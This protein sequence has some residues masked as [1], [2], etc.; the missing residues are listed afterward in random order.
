[1]SFVSE[2]RRRNVLRV[3][4][5]YLV[6]G[7]L[8]TEVL[9][10]I[11]P[12]LGAPAW[13]ARM[14]ILIFA[15]G[16]PLA[17]VLPWIYEL[18][19]EGIKR[20]SDIGK[21]DRVR[22]NTRRF[23]YF[24]FA[25]IAILIVVV[26]VLGA[27]TAIDQTES[28]AT[29]A[30]DTSIAVLPFVNLTGD[31]GNN[32]LSDGLTETLLHMLT[33]HQELLVAA[34]TSSFAFKNQDKT[35]LEIADALN[36]AHILEGSVQLAN[37]KIRITAQL[38]RAADGFHV[39]SSNFDRDFEDIFAIQDEIAKEVGRALTVS[40][41]GSSE[42]GSAAGIGTENP[43]AYDLYLQALGERAT[44]SYGGLQ[45]A[46]DLLKGAL[47]TDP[48]FL[49]AKLELALNYLH[50]AQTGL[51]DPDEAV[52]NCRALSD[53]VLVARP[54]DPVAKAINLF[55][56]AANEADVADA[57]G[58]LDA[59]VKLESLVAENPGNYEI[60]SLLARLLELMQQDDRALVVQLEA[61]Q[62]D[63]FNPR[64]NFEL[65]SLYLQLGRSNEARAA[66]EKSLE[67]E[68]QQ[69]SAYGVLA[70]VSLQQ[71]DAV[72]VVRQML[73]A[74]ETD[75]R[76]HELPGYLAVLLYDLGLVEQGDD[77]RNLVFAIAPTSDIAYQIELR[78]AIITGDASASLQSA[79][80]TIEE[81]A[82]PRQS[83]F[84][85][86]VR[87]LMTSAAADG[88][89]A[90]ITA[91]LEKH[92]PG[93]FDINAVSVPLKYRNAQIA[94]LDAWYLALPRSDLLQRLDDLLRTAGMV[95]IDPLENPRTRLGTQALRGETEQAIETALTDVFSRSVATNLRWRETFAQ[96][97]YADIVADE[98]V[99]AALQ[100]WEAE[101]DE[102]REQVRAFLAD[103]SSGA[104]ASAMAPDGRIPRSWNIA[105]FS[106]YPSVRCAPRQGD[107]HQLPG[108]TKQC[109]RSSAG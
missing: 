20:E 81:N 56:G 103:L 2:L 49:D 83:T 105:L 50:Q 93:I 4:F 46:E 91:Y 12:E 63:P 28:Q 97:Q 80:R 10:T 77:F 26:A 95:G 78:R 9:T 90:E 87:Y 44:F 62:Q 37:N 109:A 89:V 70:Q 61:L 18:T 51:M 22:G 58:T 84:S 14:V 25:A 35:I 5:A 39:W 88:D 59:I 75:P 48:D 13:A 66:L 68:P 54:D 23:D 42:S 107:P 31:E 45:A 17:I 74:F 33:Q 99:R 65:G 72:D 34:R 67:I 85:Q 86:A 41:L 43:D 7:W 15:F 76:D 101:Y 27:R 73:K 11:L 29:T 60:Q 6:V 94:A 92:A 108:N 16:F 47:A 104:R 30:T 21:D 100:R 40:L 55:I 52:S 69:P 24:A 19:P 64:I 3:V 106:V 53:Q 57:S 96:A 32:Y 71:G 82:G 36:V 79:R 98:R 8:L 38:I 102:M 1:M